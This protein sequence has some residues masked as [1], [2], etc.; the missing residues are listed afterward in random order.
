MKWR[1]KKM[2]SAEMRISLVCDIEKEERLLMAAQNKSKKRISQ[3]QNEP[4]KI[5]SSLVASIFFHFNSCLSFLAKSSAWPNLF[6]NNLPFSQLFHDR[7]E[8]KN[9]KKL[10]FHQ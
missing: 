2:K 4:E 3:M 6:A 1:R 8:K 7:R 10:K 9:G 5:V